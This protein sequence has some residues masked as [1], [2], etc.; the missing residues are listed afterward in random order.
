MTV[1][2]LQMSKKQPYRN[3]RTE[4]KTLTLRLKNTK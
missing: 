1:S 4:N 2:G 3:L